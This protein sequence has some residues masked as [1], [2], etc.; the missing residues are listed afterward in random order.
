M[1][2]L[3]LGACMS[4]PST[5]FYKALVGNAPCLATAQQAAEPCR[6]APG[7]L[8]GQEAVGFPFPHPGLAPGSLG[9]V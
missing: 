5:C 8:Q 1:V 6:A 3:D 4:R 9:T 7:A 2:A